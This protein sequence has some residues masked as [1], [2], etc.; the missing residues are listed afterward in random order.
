MNIQKI[1]SYNA[2]SLD[3]LKE[4]L[5]ISANVNRYDGELKRLIKT[6]VSIAEKYIQED[7]AYT[8]N[9]LTDYEVSNSE[10]RI[11]QPNIVISSISGITDNEVSSISGYSIQKYSSFT[12]IKFAEKISVDELIIS[13]TSGYASGVP[14]DLTAAIFI[15]IAELFEVDKTGYV[16]GTIRESKAFQRIL[17]SYINLI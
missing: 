10:Y 4:H 11:A 17:S 8:T 1:K 2:F 12:L 6:A 15:K 3:E 7:I 16:A 13:Y 14:S 9:V 5:N